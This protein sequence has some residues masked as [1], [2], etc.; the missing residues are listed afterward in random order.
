MAQYTEETETHVTIKNDGAKEVRIVTIVLKDG[1]EVGRS[2]HRT[3]I[4]YD[5]DVPAK[6]ENFINAKKGKQPKKE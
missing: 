5:A 3:I 1:V 2:N 6:I 4:P